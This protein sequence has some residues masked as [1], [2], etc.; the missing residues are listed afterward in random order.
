MGDVEVHLHHDNASAEELR[1]QLLDF[2]RTLHERHGLLA[3]NESGRISYGFIHGNWTLD[4]SRPDGRLCGVNNELTVLRETGCYADFTLPSAPDLAQTRIINSI[5]Y[6]VDDPQRPKSHDRGT[7]AKVGAAPPEASL[8]LIQGPLALEWRRRKW[9]ILPR[10]EN[11]ELHG[12]RPPSLERLSLWLQAGV[13]VVGR[14]EWRF[15]KLHTHG[16]EERNCEMLLGAPM[17]AFH[18]SLAEYARRDAGF[19]YFCVTA[20]E[21]A[22]LVGQ[23]EQGSTTPNWEAMT[24][25]PPGDRQTSAGHIR[26]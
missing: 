5:Y 2:T 11:G 7:P 22:A 19:R 26:S 12:G 16:A 3:K 17:R 14:P 18:E 23:A 13:S 21:M 25:L 15:I 9:K 24:R 6:A 1:E 20:R 4:N 10:L 8:L